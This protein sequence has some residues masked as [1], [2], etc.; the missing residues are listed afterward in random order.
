MT[1]IVY[2]EIHI[3]HEHWV[4]QNWRDMSAPH[5]RVWR[6]LRDILSSICY[7]FGLCL[8]AFSREVANLFGDGSRNS[9]P[10]FGNEGMDHHNRLRRGLFPLP[11]FI[12][13]IFLLV[14][15]LSLYI[16]TA[17]HSIWIFFCLSCFDLLN[18]V[19]G[20]NLMEHVDAYRLDIYYW[21]TELKP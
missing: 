14:S 9:I 19:L 1:I 2:S 7:F 6:G 10:L 13:S 15:P 3:V 4:S 20:N 8:R 5:Q 18:Q 17:P 12:I 11:F 16:P 21:F